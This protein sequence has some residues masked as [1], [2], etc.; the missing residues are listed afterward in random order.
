MFDSCSNSERF[1]LS[2][3]NTENVTD[4]SY[5]FNNNNRLREIN[6]SSF[7]TNNVTNMSHMFR[8]C[9]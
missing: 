7:N 3:F 5:M 6:L 8:N 2:S 9:Y 4:M 1:Y